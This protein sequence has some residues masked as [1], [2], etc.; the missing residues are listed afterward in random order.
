MHGRPFRFAG[1]RPEGDAPDDQYATS[2][3]KVYNADGAPPGAGDAPPA[4]ARVVNE[5]DPNGYIN[6]HASLRAEIPKETHGDHSGWESGP[7]PGKVDMSAEGHA[8]SE[9]DPHSVAPDTSNIKMTP[10]GKQAPVIEGVELLVA[11]GMQECM[12]CQAIIS[13]SYV[14]GVHYKC[15]REVATPPPSRAIAGAARVH[16]MYSHSPAP[17]PPHPPP[18]GTS[19]AGTC[20]TG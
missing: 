19:V 8:P 16:A 18:P 11:S 20:A 13:E 2:P 10:Y 14:M 12:V 3:E 9:W 1:S 6:P 5:Y 17:H 7:R 4:E 15:E